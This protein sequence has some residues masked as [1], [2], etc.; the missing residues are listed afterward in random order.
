MLL[1]VGKNTLY[2]GKNTRFSH[3]SYLYRVPFTANVVYGYTKTH[4]N[5]YRIFGVFQKSTESSIFSVLFYQ[6]AFSCFFLQ[7]SVIFVFG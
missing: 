7:H 1:Y 3:S 5:L 6:A 4:V 2:S